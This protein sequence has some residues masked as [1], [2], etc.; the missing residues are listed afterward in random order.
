M[1]IRIAC[2]SDLHGHLPDVP[3]CDLLLIGGDIVPTTMHRPEYSALWMESALKPWLEKIPVPVIAVAG[4]HDL[5][6]ER[7]KDLVPPLPWT[8][9]E[10]SGTEFGGLK[11]HGSP[12]QP[13]FCDWAFNRTESQLR[14]HWAMVPE[15]TEILLLHGPP[16]GYGDVSDYSSRHLGSPSLTE[17]LRGLPKLK[18]AVCGHIHGGRGVYPF[19]DA[20]IVNAAYL[21]EQYRPRG[22][23][24]FVV[25]VEK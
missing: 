25:E 17:R 3:E 8:Y 1:K 12:V 9:L 23:E 11:V 22:G 21:D 6:F 2:V 18:L 16:Y 20:R 19:G 10:D 15:D 5:I 14:E 4:N 7:R 24:I 13:E